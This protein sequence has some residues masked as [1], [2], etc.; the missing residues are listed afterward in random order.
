MNLHQFGWS[1]FF[2]SH[3]Q[4]HATTEYIAGRIALEHKSSYLLYTDM[5]EVTGTLSGK[6]RHQVANTQ[7]RPAIGDWVVIQARAAEKT[8]TIHQVLPRK[9]QFSRKKPGAK[10]EAQIVA[11]NVDTIFLVT[12]LD[13]DFNLR[14]IERYL[15]LTWESGANPVIVLNKAD[16][17]QTVEQRIDQVEAIAAGVPICVLSAV[18]QQGLDELDQY[19]GLGQT[20]ALLG[21]SGVGKSTITNQLLGNQVQTVQSVRQ[22]DDRGKHTTTHRELFLLPQG[23]L[24]IDTPG[25]R[26]VQVWAGE[27]SLQ[28]TFADIEML[29][30]QCRFR[31][32]RHDDE[33]GCAIQQ[34]LEDGSL[35][36]S[37][38]LNYQKL[39]K[40][41]HYLTRKQDQRLQLDE[42]TRWKQITKSL[43]H[44]P[45]YDKYKY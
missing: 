3:F 31:N 4:C 29:T 42:K 18:Q 37:R 24:L 26:E 12:G 23:G 6:L 44:H 38:L 1:E 21:S 20:V 30:S 10:T 34:A 15:M 9:S 36:E 13:Q 45:K 33:P 32:C 25:M 17:C 39:Q 41:L 40:E 5:G 28:E 11:A 22:K 27:D 16:L 19:L 35:D 43:R 8:A 7:E 14:R 2:A